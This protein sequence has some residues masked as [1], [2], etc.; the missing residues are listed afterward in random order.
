M[1]VFNLHDKTESLN[2]MFVMLFYIGGIFSVS[3]AFA[4]LQL[5]GKMGK[6]RLK[7]IVKISLPVCIALMVVVT[8]IIML[9]TR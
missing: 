1:Y 3:T 8:V 6:E 9:M 5:N 4:G 7:K 2:N